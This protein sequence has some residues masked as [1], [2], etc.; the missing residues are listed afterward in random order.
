MTADAPARRKAHS[1]L[2]RIGERLEQRRADLAEERFR[3]AEMAQQFGTY[4]TRYRELQSTRAE[5][6]R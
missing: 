4:L 5:A 3:R 1:Q 2:E 6:D